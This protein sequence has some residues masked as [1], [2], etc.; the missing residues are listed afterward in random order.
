[1]TRIVP[2]RKLVAWALALAC[3][4]PSAA[5]GTGVTG[6][7]W[8][9][10]SVTC[11]AVENTNRSADQTAP[12]APEGCERESRLAAFSAAADAV[13]GPAVWAVLGV[14]PIACIYGAASL[15]FGGRKGLPIIGSALG[16]AVFMVAMRGIIA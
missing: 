13:V 2:S 7:P 6:S 11:H 14:V 9:L 3:A 5:L 4:L 1:M 16:M 10:R 15:L 12:S 8:V